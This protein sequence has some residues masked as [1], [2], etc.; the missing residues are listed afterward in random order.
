MWSRGVLAAVESTT[1]VRTVVSD[2]RIRA[3]TQHA[4]TSIFF[5]QV[6]SKKREIRV[7]KVE[8]LECRNKQTKTSIKVKIKGECKLFKK[9]VY[10]E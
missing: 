3:A 5:F 6:Y 10:L 1:T 9:N 2:L 4:S 7:P 8:S